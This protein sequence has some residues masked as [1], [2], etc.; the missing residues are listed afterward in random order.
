MRKERDVEGLI[1]ALGNINNDVR[2]DA[3][4]AFVEIGDP[5]AVE[6]LINALNDKDEHV[7][8]AAA[9]TLGKIGD[10]KA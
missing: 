10:P 8:R 7:R 2:S 9:V 6:P 1:K 3:V 4:Q 5:K